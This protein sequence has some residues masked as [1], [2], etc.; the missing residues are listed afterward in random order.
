[1]H[2]SLNREIHD[3]QNLQL[4][5]ETVIEKIKSQYYHESILCVMQ[6]HDSGLFQVS[7]GLSVEEPEDSDDSCIFATVDSI[8]TKQRDGC[9]LTTYS[10]RTSS[11]STFLY[12]IELLSELN[13]SLHDIE[14]YLRKQ[15]DEDLRHRAKRYSLIKSKISQSFDGDYQGVESVAMIEIVS[16]KH[17]ESLTCGIFGIHF[18]NSSLFIR[19]KINLCGN[20]HIKSS[21]IL[22][23]DNDEYQDNVIGRTQASHPICTSM[24]SVNN[25]FFVIFFVIIIEVVSSCAYIYDFKT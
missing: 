6:I 4:G 13:H 9:R 19:Y 21:A 7:P 20:W 23:E 14:R 12:S 25:S 1:M 18:C 17:K 16:A 11:G 5:K 3:E 24:N 10:F 2:Q 22:V 8:E 15:E